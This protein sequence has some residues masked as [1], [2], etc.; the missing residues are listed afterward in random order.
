MSLL[1]TS[2]TMSTSGWSDNTFFS[3]V[4]DSFEVGL[5]KIG[6]DVLPNWVSS[7]LGL[8]STDQLNQTT[9]N[10]DV[11]PPRVGEVT[12]V[13]SAVETGATTPAAERAV[14][15]VGNLSLDTKDLIGLAAVSIL[16][17][18]VLIKVL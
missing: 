6:S 5:K 10:Q 4:Q 12:P 17:I 2:P 18:A 15:T 13:R 8:Q 16:G 9:F 11:A 14:F 3:D 7:Q 1:G